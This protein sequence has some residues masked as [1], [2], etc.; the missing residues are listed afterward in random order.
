MRIL[1][2]IACIL[3][4]A[5]CKRADNN[6]CSGQQAC[7]LIFAEVNISIRDSNGKAVHL[8]TAYTL[9]SSTGETFAGMPYYTIDSAYNVLTDA[10]LPDVRGTSDVYYF[11]G[12]VS[13]RQVVNEPFTIAA[14]CCH[15]RYVTG[16]ETIILH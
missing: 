16:R 12:F 8:D 9:R 15:I 4:A 5:S 1:I 10:A 6:V 11:H 2:A 3:L 13:G 7:T 14:D